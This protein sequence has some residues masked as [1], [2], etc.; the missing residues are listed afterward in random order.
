M[1]KPNRVR[2]STSYIAG[3]WIGVLLGFGLLIPT[4]AALSADIQSF[5]SC[6]VN[7]SGLFVDACGKQSLNGGDAVIMLLFVGTLA[8]VICLLTHAL[9]SSRRQT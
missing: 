6:S 9:R 1:K 5:R 8:V 2:R 7:S 3:S 4:I